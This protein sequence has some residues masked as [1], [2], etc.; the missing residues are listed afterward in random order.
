MENMTKNITRE[1]KIYYKE[2]HERC[3]HCSKP[4]T[5]GATAHLGYLS[6]GKQAVLCDDC[7]KLLKETV[8]RYYWMKSGFN[9]PNPND[10]LWRYMDLAKL[11]S[12]ISNNTLFFSVASY[13]D[14]PFEGAKGL[15]ER[16]QDWDDFYLNFFRKAIVSIPG[17]KTSNMAEEKI[18]SDSRY[19][20]KQMEDVGLK[21]RNNTY[22]SCWYGNEYESE[23]M[24]KLYSKNVTNAIA[25]QTTAEHLYLSL[26]RSPEIEIGKIQYIDYNKR[27]AH[28][29]NAYWFKRKAF[30]YEHEVRAVITSF[31]NEMSGKSIPINVNI[32]IDRV[33]ISP[34]APKW[35]EEVVQSVIEKYGIKAPILHSSIDEQPFY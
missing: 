28:I 12:I 19:L 9:K 2:N 30:E 20:L 13:F 3:T 16:K 29:N 21:S 24:W 31:G 6:N 15:F 26:D 25:I 5:T 14:D 17:Q 35:F 33:F 18:E 1:L 11:I 32:L 23:A 22:I 4:F 7:S 34:Y 8:V 10:K 27:Y